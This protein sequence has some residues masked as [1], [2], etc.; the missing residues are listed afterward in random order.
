MS[1]NKPASAK[2]KATAESRKPIRIV[3]ATTPIG[4]IEAGEKLMQQQYDKAV[5]L[6]KKS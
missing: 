4:Y 2:P 5:A 1:A 6:K 3:I